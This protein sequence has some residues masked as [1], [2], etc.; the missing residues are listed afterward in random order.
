MPGVHV[1]YLN[2]EESRSAVESI[3]QSVGLTAENTTRECILKDLDP[4][5]LSAALP[6]TSGKVLKL[7]WNKNS[8][9]VTVTGWPAREDD[10]I[11]ALT[12]F[13]TGYRDNLRGA[14]EVVLS[15]DVSTDTLV[16]NARYPAYTE[17]APAMT[18]ATANPTSASSMISFPTQGLEDLPSMEAQ[19]A[20]G[21]VGESIV[22]NLQDLPVLRCACSVSSADWV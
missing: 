16:T 15:G 6:E 12:V 21:S 1:T 11:A 19:L 22:E 20:M 17:Y 4:N 3:A 2:E 9:Y 5:V 13:F 14:Q 18:E 7:R 10:I 8:R